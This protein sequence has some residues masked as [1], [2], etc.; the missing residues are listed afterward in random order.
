[1]KALF[2]IL[3]LAIVMCVAS[4]KA[5]THVVDGSPSSVSKGQSSSKDEAMDLLRRFTREAVKPAAGSGTKAPC[6]Y[7]K[8]QW[9]A[10]DP[11]TKV[12]TRTFTL[13]K[14]DV[15]ACEATKTLRKECKG[16]KK[17]GKQR[18]NNS[19]KNRSKNQNG[20]KTSRSKGSKD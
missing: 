8:G 1:M 20:E 3:V 13:K 15:N 18:N 7:R 16:G 17:G 11:Q 6:K 19:N 5:F 4:G 2:V 10:C 12:R 9:S 14:G